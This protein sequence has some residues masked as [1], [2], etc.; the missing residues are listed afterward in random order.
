MGTRDGQGLVVA[1]EQKRIA[2]VDD[3]RVWQKK[4]LMEPGLGSGWK[5]CRRC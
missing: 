5:K 2:L 1:K 3:V 4:V